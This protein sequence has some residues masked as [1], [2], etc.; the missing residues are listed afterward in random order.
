MLG[1]TSLSKF[2]LLRKNRTS[3]LYEMKILPACQLEYILPWVIYTGLF[4][5]HK[6]Q[7]VKCT[8]MVNGYRQESKPCNYIF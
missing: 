1:L 5:E 4:T 8:G 3:L 7:S 6:I 2:I